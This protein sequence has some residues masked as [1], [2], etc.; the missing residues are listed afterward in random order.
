MT[1]VQ[2]HP[3]PEP[4]HA[5]GHQE[6]DRSFLK[7]LLHRSR[8][9]TRGNYAFNENVR[10]TRSCKLNI[11]KIKF[12]SLQVVPSNHQG[13]GNLITSQV[14]CSLRP[15][16]SALTQITLKIGSSIPELDTGNCPQRILRL[17]KQ[18]HRNLP[19]LGVR[20]HE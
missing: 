1:V 18:I 11:C 13:A 12:K 15:R 7:G 8:E 20:P 2:P 4:R 19:G 9:M 16:P 6:C 10:C 14:S 3:L 5:P 17:S